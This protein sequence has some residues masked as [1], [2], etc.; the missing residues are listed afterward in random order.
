MKK[1]LFLLT[2]RSGDAGQPLGDRNEP[3]R[4]WSLPVSFG[5]VLTTIRARSDAAY[6]RLLGAFVTFYASSLCNAHWGEL[7]RA[8]P[9][10]RLEIGMNFQ[11]LDATQAADIWRPFLDWVTTQDD[12]VPTPTSIV[13]GPGRQR[14]DGAAIEKY[15]PGTIRRDDRPGAPAANFFGWPTLPRPDT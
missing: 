13:S 10:N 4:T 1:A 9:G 7:V 15:L 14:W 6:R 11:G 2:L 12:I 3:L 5:A 8:R